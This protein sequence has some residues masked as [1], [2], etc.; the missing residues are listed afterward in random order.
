LAALLNFY[1]E[2]YQRYCTLLDRYDNHI[3]TFNEKKLSVAKEVEDWKEMCRTRKKEIYKYHIAMQEYKLMHNIWFA[4]QNLLNKENLEYNV[5]GYMKD[6]IDEKIVNKNLLLAQEL[7][8]EIKSM[9]YKLSYL[10]KKVLTAGGLGHYAMV[11]G[12]LGWINC[13]RF[14]DIPFNKKRKIAL[15]HEKDTRFY[16]VFND[17]NTMLTAEKFNQLHQFAGVPIDEK[18]TL[19]GI[20]VEDNVPLLFMKSMTIEDNMKLAPVFRK[21]SVAEISHTFSSLQRNG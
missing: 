16:L 17:R 15:V 13:D 11:V 4:Q 20:R 19:V 8:R 1:E 9:A 5:R 12:Q 10:S 18:V 21:S 2:K 3:K 6:L 7:D 14:L